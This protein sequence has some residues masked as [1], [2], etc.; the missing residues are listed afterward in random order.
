MYMLNGQIDWTIVVLCVCAIAFFAIV[1]YYVDIV[2]LEQDKRRQEI[3]DETVNQ[4]NNDYINQLT[5]TKEQ[6]ESIDVKDEITSFVDLSEKK[7]RK[8]VL[9]ESEIINYSDSE[10]FS[11][12]IES[13]TVE[14]NCTQKHREQ[15]NQDVKRADNDDKLDLGDL[16]PLK[17][18]KEVNE[19]LTVDDIF[20]I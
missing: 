1:G 7:E 6:V 9:P 12:D 18:E 15:D 20:K 3:E 8:S 14:N 13:R 5:D 11:D 4:E 16:P 2:K 10:H 17:M 19:R